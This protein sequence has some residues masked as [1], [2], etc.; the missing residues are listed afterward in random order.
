MRKSIKTFR[1]VG[2]PIKLYKSPLD[3]TQ[4]GGFH[5]DFYQSGTAA[6]AAV[7]IAIKEARP[8]ERTNPEVIL[9]AYACPDL[10]S[11]VL[12]AGAR[13]VLVDLEVETCWMSLSQIEEN[14]TENTIAIIAVRF[15]GIAE[16]MLQLRELCNKHNLFLIED[17]AQGFP[18]TNPD[19][20]WNGDA[21]ILS[22]GRGK[23]V[24]MLGGGAVLINNENIKE[25]ITAYQP[26]TDSTSE[27]F[28]YLLKAT[29]YNVLIN[30]VFY[31]AM[32]KL[33]GLNIGET[34]FK[35][36]QKI[37][38]IQTSILNRINAN[39]K[40]FQ[41]HENK[42]CAIKQQLETVGLKQIIDLPSA[43]QHDFIQ[44]LLRYPLLVED[45]KLRDGLH[46]ALTSFG[47]SIMYQKP[48]YKINGISDALEKYQGNCANAE[49]FADCLI[50]LPTYDNISDEILDEIFVRIRKIYSDYF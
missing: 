4:F 41:D 31:G 33:P 17:S 36:L 3:Y 40:C 14:I 24:N 16:R 32:L 42:S 29:T 34:R 8:D 5:I 47:S 15:L 10:I 43:V 50:T 2:N 35:P 49:N 22:F 37:E 6:L 12:Y 7:I 28:S 48:L 27:T 9:P 30:P 11:A 45:K 19:T 26:R 44:P 25:H 46:Q 1:P 20:Y 23:P 39:I 13:P 18:K 21:I 38:G